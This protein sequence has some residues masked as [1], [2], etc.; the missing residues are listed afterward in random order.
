MIRT[1]ANLIS[2]KSAPKAC[3]L[4]AV[5]LMRATHGETLPKS[6]R[7]QSSSSLPARREWVRQCRN[8]SLPK[9]KRLSFAPSFESGRQTMELGW[10]KL[11][12]EHL[13]S[14]QLHGL[15]TTL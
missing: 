8:G 5:T 4:G 15:A 14:A 11:H 6:L 2:L 3:T 1:R 10:G 9:R 13:A 7:T 12:V